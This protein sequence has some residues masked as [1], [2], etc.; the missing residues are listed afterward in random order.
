MKRLFL[1]LYLLL[2]TTVMASSAV[3]SEDI[4][5]VGVPKETLAQPIKRQGPDSEI[6]PLSQRSSL[7][8]IYQNQEFDSA[9]DLRSKRRVGLG[10]QTAGATGLFGALIEL[11]LTPSESAITAFGGGPGYNAFNCQWKHTF[12]GETFSPYAGFGYARWYNASGSESSLNHTTPAALG[13]HFLTEDEKR[14]GKF[15]VDL[16]NPSIGL[17]Y[18][19][20]FGEYTGTA[21]FA[22]VDF[23]M[24]ASDLSPVPTGGVGLLYYF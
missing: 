18:N 2:S 15:T 14:S 23:L 8:A 10:V 1:S 21:A 5:I 12:G 6:T 20:L 24:R 13:S 17:Q 7:K 19:Q 4:E 3:Q 9:F 16:L 11:N 22:E